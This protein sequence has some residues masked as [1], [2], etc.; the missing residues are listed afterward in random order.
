MLPESAGPWADA[1]PTPPAIDAPFSV[2][3]Q[4][5]ALQFW[6][7]RNRLP[8]YAFADWLIDCMILDTAPFF[9]SAVTHVTG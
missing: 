9:R 7:G 4:T 1:G 5:E 8:F 6:N 2:H 3:F